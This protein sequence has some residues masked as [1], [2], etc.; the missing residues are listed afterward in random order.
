MGPF[1]TYQPIRRA[2]FA[3]GIAVALLAGLLTGCGGGEP[4]R[5]VHGL[6]EF[7][8]AAREGDVETVRAMLDAGFPPS[9][10]DVDGVTALH[11]AARDG[12]LEIAELLLKRRAPVDATTNASWTPLHL[13]VRSRDAKMVELLLQYGADPDK[14]TPE[15][16]TALHMA[17]ADGSEEIVRLLLNTWNVWE[18]KSRPVG[19]KGEVELYTE[20]VG[21]RSADLEIAD[22]NGDRA[23]HHAARAGSYGVV[24]QLVANGA[25]IDAPGAGGATA[26]HLAIANRD[27]M[28]VNMLT[29]NGADVNKPDGRGV[30]PLAMA[31]GAPEIM[32]RLW[33]KGAQ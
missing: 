7:H 29:A 6:T 32:Q 23:L 12:Q 4:K 18:V 19:D 5:D 33:E 27:A 22:E 11:R 31:Q 30:R 17:A 10:K 28:M 26:L 14:Q 3:L 21:Q 1:R 13:A 9:T 8:H 25:E 16:T 2:A 20:V 15:G 24:A